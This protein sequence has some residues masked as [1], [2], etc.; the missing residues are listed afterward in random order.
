VFVG[1]LVVAHRRWRALA[2][3][4][5]VDVVLL[6]PWRIY[7]HVH[8][9]RDIN[10]SFGDSFD[11]GHLHGRFGVGR[12]A[13]RTLGGQMLDTQQWGF[14]VPLFAVL[15]LAAFIA[16]SRAL[17]I[18][19]LVWAGLAWIGLS[20]IYVISRFE[21]SSYPRLDEGA[22]GRND[23]PRERRARSSARGRD[24]GQAQRSRA[25]PASDR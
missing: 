18:F 5:A 23:R 11:Y 9:L 16:G 21:Y 15:L 22:R 25:S 6:L 10:Y 20:W 12:I 1:L 24:L 14:V 2:V 7:V 3:A 17:P 19:G 13:F 4:A 8:H